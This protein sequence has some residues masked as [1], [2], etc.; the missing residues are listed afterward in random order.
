LDDYHLIELQTIHDLVN[1]LIQYAPKGMHLVLCTRMDPPLPLVKFRATSQVN[2]I[3]GQDLC[4]TEDEGHLL[5]QHILGNQ[6]DRTETNA[7]VAQSEGWVTGIRL[8]ALALRHRKGRLHIDG[9]LSAKNRYVMEY[10]VSEILENQ[11][12]AFSEGMLKT[13]ILERFCPEL[14]EIVC[15][16]ED[17]AGEEEI[18]GQMFLDW[19]EASNLFVIQL[20]DQGQWV[21]YHHLFRDFLVSE[22][23]RRFNPDEISALHR[24]ASAWY[25]SEGL[26]DEALHHALAIGDVA[27]AAQIV[28]QNRKVILVD[29]EHHVMARW[30]EQLPGDII[31]QQPELLLALA[32]VEKFRLKFQTVPG[33][34]EAA[35]KILARKENPDIELQGEIEFFYGYFTWAQGLGA[36]AVKHQERAL[37]RI[38]ETYDHVRGEAEVHYG[39]TLHM[40][41]Q[42]EMAIDW[43]T[44][45][46]DSH[47]STKAIRRTRH[48]SGLYFIHTLEGSLSEAIHPA[49][50]GTKI[51]MKNKLGYA[52]TFSSYVETIAYLQW[53]DLELAVQRL[54]QII[55]KRYV[56]LTRLAVDSLGS[57]CL[58]YEHLDRP[59]Q[60]DETV[61][62]LIEFA[63]QS[64]DPSLSAIAASL[65]AR[66]SLI[67]GD[68]ASAQ[69]W[70]RQ[71]D[72]ATDAGI[73]LF[74]L[75]IPRITEC[76]VLIMKGTDA[77]LQQAIEKLEQYDQENKAVHNTFQRVVILPLLALAN[78]KRGETDRALAILRRAVALAEPGGF[79]RPFV[80]LAP[81]IIGL[82]DEVRR[83]GVAPTYI[84]QILAAI[85]KA[86]EPGSPST[87]PSRVTSPLIESLTNREF[88][89]LELLGERLT[90]KEIA[91]KLH[92]SIGTVEQH[93]VRI[94]GK[95]GVRRR[96]QAVVKAKELG[97]LRSQA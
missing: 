94:Y 57:L 40:S 46:I 87:R 41:G 59:D 38:P 11:V 33:L 7:L 34:L 72:M 51:G 36:Q 20:D 84:T 47:P 81:E 31:W 39:L 71:A 22:L 80:D 58:T 70:I 83:Q 85:E 97:L 6:V 77:S 44:G 64:N 73:M 14:C 67:R 82:L 65:Q 5:V 17:D 48:L 56:A 78:H 19:L 12:A 13:S 63:E 76:R 93:L 10:L 43:L 21:R 28:K 86:E 92:I 75:E 91:A 89:I 66:L 53:N 25:A 74:W 2:E 9:K 24:R 95:L 15:A 55:T 27:E 52:E 35:E 69:R 62:I 54:K 68:L 45:L 96:R 4:F 50:L 1:E 16:P 29:D 49:Q 42:R 3:R 23:T 30:L 26:I 8:A 37:E 32:W 18:N 60:A 88:E 61:K 79:I 90:N